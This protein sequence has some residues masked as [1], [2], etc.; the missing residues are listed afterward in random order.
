VDLK[1]NYLLRIQE[2]KHDTI[3][4]IMDGKNV[5]DFIDPEIE[6][7]KVKIEITNTTS[8]SGLGNKL[9]K[10]MN[11][12]ILLSADTHT[13]IKKKDP[14]YFDGIKVEFAAEG[15]VVTQWLGINVV[16]MEIPGHDE[17]QI[18]L[19]SQDLSWVL[20]GDLFQGI[21]TVVIGGDEGDMKKYFSTLERLI[22]LSPKVVFPSHGIGLGGTNVLA[23]TLEHR[24]LREQ[25]VLNFHLDGFSA[26]EILEKIYSEV[27]KKLWPY[28][29]ENIRKHLEKLKEEKLIK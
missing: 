8:T 17:G 20:A 7:E 28:A 12:P 23:K 9:A 16:V 2:W 18:A 11:F 1:D 26:Q 25:Q 10:E 14:S 27:D 22:K 4:E 5:A 21:G 3:P 6:K 29:L 15:D 13:R 24:K 19:Y